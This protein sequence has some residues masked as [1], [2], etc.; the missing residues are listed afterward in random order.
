MK[1]KIGKI[2]FLLPRIFII[3]FFGLIVRI[4]LSPFLTLKLDQN[5]FIAWSVNLVEK[6]F[7]RFYLGWSDYFPGY[8][9]VLWFLGKIRGVFPDVFL[10]KLPA[11]LSD[12]FCGY[13][14]FKIAGKYVNEKI[15]LIISSLYLFNPAVISNSTLW[16][17]VDSIVVL[18]SL[19]SLYFFEKSIVLSAL[20]LYFGTLVKHQV[21]FL[22]HLFF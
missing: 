9:Y 1:I 12:I 14:I 22:D 21:G 15:S 20:F 8:M 3:L 19:L 7:D 18:F 16:G 13:L 4:I 6:G 11:I 17:Q 2:D 5:T 10:Y